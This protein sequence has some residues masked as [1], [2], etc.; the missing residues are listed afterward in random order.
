MLGAFKLLGSLAGT[1]IPATSSG[2]LTLAPILSASVRAQAD[3][4]A[5]ATLNGQQIQ[6]LVW[7]Y[8]DDLVAVPA[9]PVH[10]SVKVPAA[11]GSR[12]TVTHM[13]VDETHGDAYTVWVSQGSPAAPSATQIAALQQAMEPA[14]LNPAQVVDVTAGTV[15]LDFDLP[16]FGISLITLTSA[17]TTAD[18][19]VDAPV[20]ADGSVDTS[21]I[22]DGAIRDVAL[23]TA[24]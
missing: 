21:V 15:A 19:S 17:L 5:M 2:A 20:T 18:G 23:T 3:V 11:F 1:R 4:D 6:V 8:H 14:A 12:V 16:R 24:F 10:L 7:N 9:S 22:A 13:R